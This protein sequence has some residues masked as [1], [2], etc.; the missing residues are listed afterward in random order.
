MTKPLTFAQISIIYQQINQSDQSNYGDQIVTPMECVKLMIDYLPDSLWNQPDLKILDPCCG[1]GNFGAY[2]ATKTNLNNIHFNDIN[3]SRIGKCKQILNPPWITNQDA[4]IIFNQSQ[5][6]DLI[7]ANPPYSGGS[8]KNK[9]LANRFIEAAIDSLKPN[10][11]L[12]F[13]SPNNWMSFNNN[14]STLTKLLNNGQFLVIDHDCKKFFPKVGSSF[15]I[16]IW[17][18]TNQVL[19]TTVFNNYLIKDQQQLIIPKTTPFLPLYLN[20]DI[21]TIINKIVKGDRNQFNYRCDLHNFTKSQYLS[22]EQD[23]NHLYRTIHTA[24]KTRYATFKQDIYEQYLIIIPLSTYYIPYLEHH[25]NVTQSV[26]YFAFAT[27]NQAQAYL[28][29]LNQDHIKV[30]IH[31]TRYGNFNNLK[32]LKQL[33]F[34]LNINFNQDER[35]L[36]KSLRAKIKY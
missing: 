28:K 34:S 33:D 31:L 29:N 13:I 11:Y 25:T 10:G 32:V 35:D 4:F 9:S 36:I 26:G 1:N 14:N 30:L 18:K 12:C 21:L 24:R 19:T 3:S 22:D 7:V 2:L 23:Q 6:Y 17:Q 5:K 8:N 27:K 20:A 15:V 16:M